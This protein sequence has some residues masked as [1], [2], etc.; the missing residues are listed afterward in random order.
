MCIKLLTYEEWCDKHEE[1]INIELAESG[2]DR[3]LDFD[4]ER[5]FENRYDDYIRVMMKIKKKK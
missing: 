1:E 4:P 2:A 3:E 5:E